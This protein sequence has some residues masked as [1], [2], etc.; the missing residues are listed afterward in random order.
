MHLLALLHVRLHLRHHHL[1]HV[2]DH[3]DHVVAAA[4]AV[5]AVAIPQSSKRK[6]MRPR[7]I[8]LAAALQSEGS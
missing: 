6:L 2:A 1:K 8:I 7:L 4:V 5:V 3:L